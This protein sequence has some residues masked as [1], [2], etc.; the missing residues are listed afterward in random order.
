MPVLIVVQNREPL[1][2]EESYGRKYQLETSR[3][4]EAHRVLPDKRRELN[5]EGLSILLARV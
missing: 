2:T 3:V 5:P 1:R 4:Q